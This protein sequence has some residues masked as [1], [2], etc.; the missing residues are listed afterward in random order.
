MLTYPDIDPILLQI[1]PLKIHWYG[2]MYLAG[3]SMAWWL[4]NKRLQHN[5]IFTSEQ[6]S[7][8]I[9]YSAVGIVLGG[10]LGYILFYNLDNYIEEPL[11]MLKIWQGG[12][13]FHGGFVGVLVAVWL[14]ARK[15]NLPFFQVTDFIAPLIPFGLGAGRIGNFING[16]LWGR[17][18]DVPWGM[19]FSKVDNIPRHP[20]QLY[21]AVLEGLV[22]FI[23]LWI[24]SK[25][26]R[27]IMAVSG[28]FLVCYGLFRFLIEFVREP[29]HGLGFIA[30]DWMTMGQILTIPMLIAGVT[31]IILAYRRTKF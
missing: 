3:F 19:V 10:R 28:L 5:E 22:L 31:L 11:N 29:D 14:Y 27:P 6:L 15:L 17:H 8:L 21:Q 1:G 26:P 2:I 9:F 23:I 20:S 12:M 16:E 25:R 13:S 24:F 4:G 18:T 7:D 30:F